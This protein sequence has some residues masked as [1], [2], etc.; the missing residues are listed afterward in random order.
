M[1]DTEAL[2]LIKRAHAHALPDEG[3]IRERLDAS[4]TLSDLGVASLSAM[5]MAAFVEDELDVE[6]PDDEMANMGS[7]GDLI[8]LIQKYGG[9]K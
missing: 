2:Q 3:A 6:F 1:N 7:I 4:S 8:R 5:E 9:A